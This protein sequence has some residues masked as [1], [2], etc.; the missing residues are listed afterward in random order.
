[1]DTRALLRADLIPDE[2]RRADEG[3]ERLILVATAE[4][5]QARARRAIFKTI[6]LLGE[7]FEPG[8]LRRVLGRSRAK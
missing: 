3:R 5:S 8:S 4:D 2:Q 1:M 7:L 6:E